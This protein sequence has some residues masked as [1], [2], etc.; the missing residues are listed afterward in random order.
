RD[1]AAI[2]DA[3]D[4]EEAVQRLLARCEI[5][6]SPPHWPVAVDSQKWPKTEISPALVEELE[7]RMEQLDPA[8]NICLGMRC[9]DC[10]HTWDAFLDVTA[11]FWTELSARARQLLEAV[12]RLASAYGWREADILSLSP[13]RRAAYLNMV[14]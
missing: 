11:C 4:P 2:L 8:A 10:G 12:H 13:A 14:G 1:Q 7:A 3:A 5:D 9:S 6:E